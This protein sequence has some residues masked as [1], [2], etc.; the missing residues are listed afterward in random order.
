LELEG[1]Y[2]RFTILKC[3]KETELGSV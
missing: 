1:P 3:R 2:S